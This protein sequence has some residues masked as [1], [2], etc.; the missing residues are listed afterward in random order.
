MT[1]LKAVRNVTKAKPKTVGGFCYPP[2]VTGCQD[3]ILNI[4]SDGFMEWVVMLL[5]KEKASLDPKHCAE[6]GSKS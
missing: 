4:R 3:K 1:K 6:L 5:K 2:N